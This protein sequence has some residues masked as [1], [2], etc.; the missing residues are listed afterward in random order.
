[1]CIRDRLGAVLAKRYKL[2]KAESLVPSHPCLLYTSV[3]G[4]AVRVASL[5]D[6]LRIADASSD[7]D[8]R[9]HALAYGAVLDVLYAQRQV[10]SDHELSREERV[11]AWLSHQTPVT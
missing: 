10:R 1:M 4:G 11:E 9:R 5:L 7:P 3:D 6:L 8:A 2:A